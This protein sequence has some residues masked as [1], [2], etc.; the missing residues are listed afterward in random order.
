MKLPLAIIALALCASAQAQ[1][2]TG[3]NSGAASDAGAFASTGDT[4]IQGAQ[5]HKHSKVDTTPSVYT[6]PSMFGGANNCGQ[7]STFGVGVTGGGLGG[8]I[9]SESDNCNNREDTSISYKLGFPDVAQMRFFCFGGDQNRMAWEATGRTC[10]DTA[11]AKGIQQR[12]VALQQ[13]RAASI[14]SGGS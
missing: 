13:Q 6:S 1:V 3:S 5:S 2:S 4:I 11:T 10:P 14:Y 7:S 12:D 9:A 8:S